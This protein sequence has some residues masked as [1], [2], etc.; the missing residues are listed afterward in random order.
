VFQCGGGTQENAPSAASTSV[1]AVASAGGFV[2][3]VFQHGGIAHENV[4]SAAGASIPAVAS[5]TG[6]KRKKAK[7]VPSPSMQKRIEREKSWP[8]YDTG[9]SK[10]TM[11]RAS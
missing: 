2:S 8:D 6:R 3:Q 10:M 11:D 5:T 1:P 4:P 9:I 7:V